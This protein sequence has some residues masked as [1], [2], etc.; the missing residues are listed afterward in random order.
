MSSQRANPDDQD[1]ASPTTGFLL[2]ACHDLRT[3]LRAVLAH[4]E[5]LGRDAGAQRKGDLA[6]RLGFIMDGARRAN[7]LVDGI[8]DYSVALLI[9]PS[10][11]QPTPMDVMLRIV[12]AKLD[13]ELRANRAE[14][15]YA[16]LPRV[17][18]NADRLVQL[19]EHL[20]GN[21]LRYRGDA[22]PRIQISAER[23]AG[24]WLFQVQDNGRGVDGEFLE[25]I[26]EPFE[27]LNSNDAAGAGL[28][29]AICRAIVERHGGRIWVE[30]AP[31]GGTRFL[32]TLP[33][34]N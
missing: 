24:A 34:P 29:L 2:R 11:F 27:R 15:K 19:F 14:V 16:H 4:A 9:D 31:G 30:P 23:Q 17:A 7:R 33:A 20:L 26:F 13:G 5:L 10:E 21:A 25:R 18:G 28:G 1:P 22:D 32:F 12:L 6:E 3:P 8:A